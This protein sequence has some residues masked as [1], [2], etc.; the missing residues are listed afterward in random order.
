[1]RLYLKKTVTAGYNE[2]EPLHAP[3]MRLTLKDQK[4][5]L[6]PRHGSDDQKFRIFKYSINGKQH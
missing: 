2:F 4:I 6:E 5:V 1:M 3:T